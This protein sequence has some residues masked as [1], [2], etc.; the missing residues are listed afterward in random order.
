[1]ARA[2]GVQTEMQLAFAGLHQL[3][4]PM[5]DHAENLPVPQREALRIAFGISAGISAASSADAPPGKKASRFTPS[6]A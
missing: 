1:M 6:R 2:I 4:G 3:C 5:L